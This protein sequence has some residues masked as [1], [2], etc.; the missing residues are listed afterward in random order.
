FV[1]N[2]PYEGGTHLPD[3]FVF[4]PVF[5]ESDESD[6]GDEGDEGDRDQHIAF[7]V[8]VAHH[9]DIG[10]RVAGGN[11]W[12]S[13]EIYQEGFRIPPVRLCVEGG[14]TADFL[15]LLST[16][17]RIPM[18]VVGDLRA[19]LAACHIG[20]RGLLDLLARHGVSMLQAA[21]ADMLEYTERIA[22]ATI[23]RLP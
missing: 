6:E 5:Y 4:Q 21:F 8:T 12:D 7:A 15:R 17:V 9:T 10:G 22:R 14:M 20:E 19:Q 18:K 16:N 23:E 2:D 13:T 3:F 11:G 1:L